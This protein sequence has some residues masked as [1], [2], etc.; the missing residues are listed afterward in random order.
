MQ[1][2]VG[3]TVEFFEGQ[4]LL[5]GLTENQVPIRVAVRAMTSLFTS[6]VVTNIVG[7]GYSSRRQV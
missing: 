6:C 2:G 7:T 3:I 5:V 4:P 1:D